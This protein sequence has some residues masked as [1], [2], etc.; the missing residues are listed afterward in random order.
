MRVAIIHEHLAQD[1]GAERVA[2]VFLEM[3]PKA[4]LYTLVHNPTQALPFFATRDVR[5][6]FLQK[7]PGG[8]RFYQWYVNWMP[9]AVERFDLREFDLV[10]SSASA[11]AKGV[12]TNPQTLHVSYLHSPTR[13]LWSD[14]HQY[15]D[16]L[17][18]PG[19]M[20]SLIP[21]S[22]TKLRMWDRLAADRPDVYIANSRLVQNRIQKYYRRDSTI[23]HP[24]VDTSRYSLSTAKPEYYLTGGRLVPY[25]RFDLAVQAFN[26]LGLPLKIYGSGPALE[27][28]K[29]MA[30][31]NI[32]FLGRVPDE[33]LN[34]LYGK[35][36]AF[37]YP[38]EEDFGI[39]AIEAMATGRPVIAYGAGGALDTVKPG[40]TGTLFDDQE[41]ES[42]ADT[43]IRF[44]P[45][46]FQPE[47]IRDWALSFG[48]DHFKQK[49]THFIDQ[50]W[51]THQAR[52]P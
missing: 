24:P 35:A 2:K 15:V 46:V 50:A 6:S 21:F 33:Q 8:V 13:Y 9:N 43:V 7:M 41:W 45:E 48:H 19:W 25:K 10:I 34:D 42:L 29:S 4:P 1:G 27:K 26:K 44:Q 51:Q 22:L 39:T 23:I 11:F 47:K 12:I 49:F 28:L 17:P 31:K 37:L 30:K 40:E 3:Y 16:E 52:L 14:T 18:Y 38:Q 32:E 20:R 5:T 36:I